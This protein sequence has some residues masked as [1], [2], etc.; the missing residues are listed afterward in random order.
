LRIG[1]REK[2]RGF[3]HIRREVIVESADDEI[4]KR[5]GIA[6]ARG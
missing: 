2:P 1:L 4:V 6:A 5:G 3:E